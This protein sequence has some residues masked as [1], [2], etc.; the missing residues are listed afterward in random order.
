[1]TLYPPPRCPFP[2]SPAETHGGVEK[3]G[4]PDVDTRLFILGRLDEEEGREP[5][6]SRSRQIAYFAVQCLRYRSTSSVSETRRARAYSMR[7]PRANTRP[8]RA[9]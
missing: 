6:D 4:S 5:G 2:E 3:L 8:G 9:S 7:K 1:M